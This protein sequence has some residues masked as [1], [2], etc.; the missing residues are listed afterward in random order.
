MEKNIAVLIPCYNEGLSIGAVVSNFFKV[1]PTCR[2]CVF[3]N[4]STDN[5]IEEAIAAGAEIYNVK[6]QGK[7][8]VVRR[9]FADIE[10]D[11]YLIVDGDG[12]YPAVSA[13][14]LL[15]KFLSE[16]ADLA[17]GR[18]VSSHASAYRFG[19]VFGNKL[20]SGVVKFIFG[21][22]VDDLLSGYRF[23][24]R[25]F[26]KSFPCESIGFEIE[27]ELS[28]HALEM[29]MN[30]VEVDIPYLPRHL[31]SVS[32]LNTYKDGIKI[33]FA[34][35]K[36][37]R[38]LRPFIYFGSLGLLSSFLSVS[39]GSIV[40]VEFMNT[41]FITKIPTAILSA[42]LGICSLVFFATGIILNSVSNGRKELKRY[43]FLGIPHHTN[44][45]TKY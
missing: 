3:N 30:I 31:G 36:L 22:G 43:I 1:F 11:I 42:S 32:K 9:M 28:V 5:T 17:I 7:G 37:F 27:T 39:F 14:I 23:M 40:I 44:V 35:L 16:K 25:R 29:R 38:E 34:I 33:F 45:F 21:E 26:V 15:N 2:V 8:N 24:S 4:N 10:A 20:L 19:H 13:H 12:T 18:R 6:L 41:G